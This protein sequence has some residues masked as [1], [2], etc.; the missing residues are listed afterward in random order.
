MQ[1]FVDA[2]NECEDAD[3]Q[4]LR[5]LAATL[6]AEGNE[7]SARVMCDGGVPDDHYV[8][9]PGA[10]KLHEA[11]Q[12]TQM[13]EEARVALSDGAAFGWPG[14]V[15]LNFGMP[16]SWLEEALLRLDRLLAD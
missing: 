16:R 8:D 2:A 11:D 12:Q 5:D 7:P 3:V 15:R 6:S 10:G 14:F 9:D 1:S 4:E 13:L